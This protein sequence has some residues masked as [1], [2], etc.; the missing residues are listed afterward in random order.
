L[1]CGACCFSRLETY[2]RV[3]GEDYQRLGDRAESLTRWIDNRCYLSLSGEHCAALTIDRGGKQF[4]CTIYDRRPAIC[5]DLERGSPECLGE[6]ATK[7]DRPLAA[8]R[9]G[10]GRGSLD[11]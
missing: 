5:R 6:R 8:L 10:D 4:V 11:G 9:R 3:T 1:E 2:A 7:A